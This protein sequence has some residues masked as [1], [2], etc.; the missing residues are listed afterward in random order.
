MAARPGQGLPTFR[1]RLRT[2][3]EG[4]ACVLR[5]PCAF[6]TGQ[7]WPRR[8]TD[9]P[10]ISARR[11]GGHGAHHGRREGPG[12]GSEALRSFD[13]HWHMPSSDRSW[14]AVVGK[15]DGQ[16]QLVWRRYSDGVVNSWLRILGAG[17][18][19]RP[20]VCASVLCVSRYRMYVE[21][22]GR[23]PGTRHWV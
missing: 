19:R 23:P 3:T 17:I 6:E 15:A 5:H 7:G 1:R 18:R 13:S 16:W 11:H 9:S 4:L 2:P 12:G 10:A 22:V 8:P 20:A 14:M 21:Q